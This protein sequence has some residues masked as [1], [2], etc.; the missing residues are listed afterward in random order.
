[1]SNIKL[2]MN[3]DSVKAKMAEMLGEKR[4]TQFIASVIQVANSSS[5]L[6]KAEPVSVFNAAAMAATLDLP[7]NNSLGFAYIIPYNN[8]QPDGT[9]KTVAQFQIGYKG[10]IQLALR[11]GQFQTVSAA[12]VYEGQLVSQNPLT[13]FEFDWENKKS[14]SLLGY[15][16]Y[17][18]LINGFEKTI[19]MTVDQL[20]KHGKR[21]SKTYSKSN[22]LWQNDFESMA[23]KTVIKL[24]L[25]KYAPLSIEMQSAVIADQSL[26]NNFET[27]DV[28]YIDIDETEINKEAERI[29]LLIEQAGSKEDLLKL[30]SEVSKH[31]SLID[32]YEVKLQSYEN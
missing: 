31:E 16:G 19:F 27:Q 7:L 23:I 2:F 12:P 21:F 4:A 11:S 28:S 25:S 5:L 15:A 18:K 17:F 22:S 1:M 14:D 3:Q 29:Y 24:L 32:A 10:F 26:V 6:S 8:R 9:T 13:G 20:N 30:E